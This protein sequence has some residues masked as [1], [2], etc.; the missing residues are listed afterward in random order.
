MTD[1]NSEITELLAQAM[2]AI[3]FGHKQAAAAYL[4]RI[5]ELDP[6]NMDAWRWLA[7]CMPNQAKRNYC[8]ERAGLAG[9]SLQPRVPA[10][11]SVYTAAPSLIDVPDDGPEPT[12][13]EKHAR[14][15]AL[16]GQKKAEL[17]PHYHSAMPID[18]DLPKAS[19]Q[20][21]RPAQP[22]PNVNRVRQQN[23]VVPLARKPV[24]KPRK[25]V[26]FKGLGCSILVLAVF[27]VG[28]Y[29]LFSTGITSGDKAWKWLTTQIENNLAELFPGGD[30]KPESVVNT[31]SVMATYFPTPAATAVPEVI[32]EAAVREAAEVPAEIPQEAPVEQQESSA[33]E[34]PAVESEAQVTQ[35]AVA[36][37]VQ[38]QPMP[39]DNDP[40]ANTGIIDDSPAVNPDSGVEIDSNTVTF[41]TPA[42]SPAP[43][44][45]PSQPSEA[46]VSEEASAPVQEVSASTAPASAASTEP[47]GYVKGPIVIGKSV[48][49]NNIEIMQFGNGPVER[50]MVAG[51]HGGN[52]WNTTALADELI[53]YIMKNP[54]VIPGDRTLYILRLLNP[55]GE[56][57]GHNLD[58]RT[59]E[60]GVDINRNFDAFWVVDWP[61]DGCWNYRPISAGSEPFSEPEAAALR[62]FVKAHKISAM[63][64]YHSAAMGIFAGGNPP[65]TDS[66]NLAE[67]ISAV[68][69]Y[70]YPPMNTG[71]KYTGQMADWMSLHGIAAVDLELTNHTDTDFDANRTVLNVL[72]KWE[73]VAS[74]K[75]LSGLIKI[76]EELPNKPSF[77]Q[78]V[79]KFGVQTLNTLNGIIFGVQE[80]K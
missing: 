71:C 50:L 16:R 60:R 66:I 72:M 6:E 49:G 56:E 80:E 8:L 9:S 27:V 64:N 79:R 37:P 51:V 44:S 23:T 62:D 10:R 54:K 21:R 22:Q 7:E 61:R 35:E 57:R 34:E 11:N 15:A 53:A 19:S 73:P 13:A 4:N 28:G 76:A 58:G 45:A 32:E 18:F 43:A 78:Q 42:V 3:Q 29:G 38:P 77:P 75:T 41:D 63:I 14:K 59:N 30:S 20:N 31:N 5:L 67:S 74:Q 48:K 39:V 24:R 36:A 33:Q 12:L 55:D 52:E 69:D 65:D 46:V 17:P 47:N 26:S 40:N 1:I 70:A 68:T 25:T 2:R